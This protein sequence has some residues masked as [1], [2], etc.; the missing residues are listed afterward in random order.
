[1]KRVQNHATMRQFVNIHSTPCAMDAGMRRLAAVLCPS[2]GSSV[3]A[4]EAKQSRA[5]RRLWI[6]SL[7]S[8]G[9]GC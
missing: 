8:Q 7:R 9:R 3:I 5:T 1:L 2:C 4:S 6:A